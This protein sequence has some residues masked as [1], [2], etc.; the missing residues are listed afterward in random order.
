MPDIFQLTS[1]PAFWLAYWVHDLDPFIFTVEMGGNT[2]GPRWYGLGYVAGF[3]LSWFLLRKLSRENRFPVPE[4]QLADF[5]MYASIFGV[6]L[7]GRLGSM[8][9][10]D[11]DSFIGDP[12]SIFRVWEGGMSSHGG[13]LGLMIFLAVYARLKQVNWVALGDGVVA[14]APVG[15]LLVR[16]A[17]FINGELYGRPTEVPWAVKF[18]GEIATNFSP[19]EYQG[20]MQTA[21][22]IQPGITN[23][24]ELSQAA[25]ANEQLHELLENVLTPR[26]PSQLYEAFLEGLVLFVILWIV[27]G[28]FRPPVGLATGLF[29][30]VY[31]IFRIAV[32]NVREPDVGVAFTLGL[33]RGQ[34]LSVFM[35]FVG[36]GF[37]IYAWRNAKEGRT[38]VKESE[39]VRSSASSE[40]ET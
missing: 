36:A 6:L 34:F 15:I 38:L 39:A 2:I 20:V 29:F 10:Y 5:V 27:V 16:L 4:N 3:V 14:V 31:A 23:V 8:L 40:S 26:H 33:T 21:N 19:L 22:Q 18:P 17:N 25:A 1:W 11:L 28:R 13:I 37:L 12:M 35:I 32:E 7:G 24:Q 30:T 9:F